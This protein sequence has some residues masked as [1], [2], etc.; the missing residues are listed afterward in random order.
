MMKAASGFHTDD[1]FMND[2]V[3]D[4]A[5]SNKQQDCLQQQSNLSNSK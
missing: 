4:A 3:G 1:T 2:N 5:K